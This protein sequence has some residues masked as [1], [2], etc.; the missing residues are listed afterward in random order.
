MVNHCCST[1]HSEAT[2]VL[3]ANY[4]NPELLRKTIK[5]ETKCDFV[6]GSD[7]WANVIFLWRDSRYYYVWDRKT[8]DIY[9]DDPVAAI[10]CKCAYLVPRTILHGL[11]GVISCVARG[12]FADVPRT[13][14]YA[15]ACTVSAFYG[16]LCPYEGRRLYALYERGYN[17]DELKMDFKNNRYLA[18]C[19]APLNYNV[20]DKNVREVSAHEII[21]NTIKHKYGL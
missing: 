10:W 19:F 12:V 7:R 9:N 20:S 21:R 14:Y 11:V 1:V 18:L 3:E 13:L 8:G 15:G 5:D 4:R 2:L 17:R 6:E 16:L